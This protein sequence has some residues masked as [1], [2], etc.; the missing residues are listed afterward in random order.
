MTAVKHDRA[1][2][3]ALG[4]SRKTKQWKNKQLPWSE[5]LSRLATT[6]RTPETLAEYKA[7]RRDRQ[8]EIKDVGG[9]V[10]GYCNDGS[11]TSVAH[12]SILCLDADFADGDLWPDWELLYGNAAAVY[13][14]HKH[15]PGKPRLRLVVPLTRDVT[16]DEYQAIGRRVAAVLGIDKFDDTTYQPQRVMFWPSTSQDG[17]YVFEYLDAPLLD[18]DKVL[19]TYHNWRDVSSWPMSS[20]VA[21]IAKKTA[22]K[23]KDPLAKGGIVGTFCRAYTIQEAIAEYVPDYVPCDEPGRYTYA[24]GSTAAGVVVYDDKFTYSHHATDPASGQLV[25]AW[26]LVRLH[27]F[28]E[29]DEDTDPDIPANKRPSYTAMS[30]LAAEDNRFKAQHIKDLQAEAAEDFA[31]PVEDGENWET[32]LEYTTKGQIAQTIDNAAIVLTHDPRLAGRL[33]YNELEHSPV[34]LSSLPWGKGPYPRKWGDSDDK[35]LRAYLEKAYKLTAREKISDAVGN[36]TQGASFHPILEYLD[37]CE[38]DGVPRVETLLI[39]YLG[40]EDTAYTRAVTRKTLTAA[41]ARVKRPGC[42]FDYMLTLHGRQGL[43]KSTL[44]AKLAGDWFSESFTIMQG[45]EAYEQLQGVWIVEVGELAAM[46]KTETEIIKQFISKRVDRFRPA[47]GKAQK[48]FP[49]QC[50]FIG[51]TNEPQFL[52]DMTGNRRF[53]IVSTPNEPRLDVQS[54]LTD[55]TVRL[56]WGEAVQLYNNSEKLYLPK[57]LEAEA[58]KVQASYEE[59]NPRAGIIADYLERLLPE[60]WETLDTYSRRAWLEGSEEGTTRRQ[61]VCTLELWAEALGG[62]PDKIDRYAV[63]EINGIMANIPGW[64]Y[65]GDN[66]KTIRPYG[67][68]RYY[69]RRE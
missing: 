61:A 55:E 38:W 34:I 68:Q 29:L 51:T 22:A 42:K 18:P 7:M 46:R 56:I 64:Q 43:G 33:A 17:E 27:R 44:V 14:T 2:D 47:Y 50:I 35:Q 16:P 31:A 30:K 54:D 8:A 53:W 65:R 37:S 67:R 11:R 23:Q 63:K 39:D 25:N 9:F 40:A 26:D 66:K 49:R 59:E 60:N 13:S 28:A 21:E 48:D 3:V 58:R 5:L 52:R 19:A 32:R 24:G 41:V 36:V 62:N 45:K 15:T 12:R 57:E 6:T 69:E 20:R 10:G 4:N 1:L